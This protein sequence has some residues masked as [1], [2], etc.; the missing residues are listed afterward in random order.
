[1]SP[2]HWDGMP[3]S[4]KTALWGLLAHFPKLYVTPYWVSI[5]SVRLCASH[6]IDKA[7]D[8]QEPLPCTVTCATHL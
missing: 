7:F 4:A 8:I 5:E 1:M 3:L 2:S 6:T